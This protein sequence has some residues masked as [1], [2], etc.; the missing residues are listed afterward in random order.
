MRYFSVF[1]Q[2]GIK[3]IYKIITIPATEAIVTRD[4]VP[5]VL[6][7]LR[8]AGVAAGL[9]AAK[10]REYVN[11][12]REF[13]RFPG[14]ESMLSIVYED[15]DCFFDYLPENVFF[16]QDS[17]DELEAS[18]WDF[19]NSATLNYKTAI[20]E[21]RLCVLPDSIYLKWDEINSAID[22]Q[23]QTSFKTL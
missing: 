6:G 10:I 15:L 3:E 8:E 17:M 13:G 5:H 14:I 4:N 16:I 7:R 18:A 1:T 19:Q 20:S 21:N 2:R 12:I 11:K 22:S 9:D 23:K